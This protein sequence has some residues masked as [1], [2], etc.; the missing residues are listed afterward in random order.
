MGT[1]KPQ[2]EMGRRKTEREKKERGKREEEEE[3]KTVGRSDRLLAGKSSQQVST[4]R[5]SPPDP[6][7]LFGLP[8]QGHPE[9]TAARDQ[10]DSKETPRT[11]RK[12]WRASRWGFPHT[13]AAVGGRC[14][15]PSGR[16]AREGSDEVEDGGAKSMK[17]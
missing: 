4:P 1:V 3:K 12:G 7:P 2:W 10:Y 6:L 11:R 13:D 5:G 9:D 16:P 14:I 8:L 17:K 15:N